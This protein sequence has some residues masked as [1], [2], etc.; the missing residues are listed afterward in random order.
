MDMDR[1]ECPKL[2]RTHMDQ[3]IPGGASKH[4]TQATVS[5]ILDDAPLAYGFVGFLHAKDFTNRLENDTF[6]DD[7]GIA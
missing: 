2:Y 4:Q 7:N 5:D 1:T 3:T 6:L